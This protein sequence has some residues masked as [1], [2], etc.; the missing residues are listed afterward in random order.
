VKVLGLWLV[1]VGYAVFYGG[2]VTWGG[3][4]MSIPQALTGSGTVSS[5]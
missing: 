4:T 2:I 5:S 3:G 1:V